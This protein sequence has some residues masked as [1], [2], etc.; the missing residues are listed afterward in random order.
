[1]EKHPRISR[2]IW[3]I[4]LLDCLG[5]QMTK[6]VLVPSGDPVMLAAPV[7]ARVYAFDKDKMWQTYRLGLPTDAWLSPPTGVADG[8]P[9]MT[10][11]TS[12]HTLPGVAQAFWTMKNNSKRASYEGG[13]PAPLWTLHGMKL[14]DPRADST[15]PGGSGAQRRDDWRTWVYILWD[16]CSNFLI[17]PAT[18]EGVFNCSFSLCF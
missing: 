1:M 11:W 2:T 5:C 14:W 18:F 16:K 12:S 3:L 13:V 4:A 7:K 9:S 8:S 17:Y 15:Y 10:E 6:V